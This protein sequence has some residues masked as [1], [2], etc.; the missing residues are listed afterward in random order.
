MWEW[1]KLQPMKKRKEWK[2]FELERGIY[3]FWKNK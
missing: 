2:E 3:N 1:V